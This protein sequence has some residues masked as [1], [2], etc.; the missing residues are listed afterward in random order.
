MRKLANSPQ[1]RQR[2]TFVRC[3]ETFMDV[4]YDHELVLERCIPELLKVNNDPVV[5]VRFALARYVVRMCGPGPSPSP[6]CQ[7]LSLCRLK[8]TDPSSRSDGYCPKMEGAPE[9]L[10]TIIDTLRNDESFDVRQRVAELFP[11]VEAERRP[12]AATSAA[13][14]S[15]PSPR[16]LVRRTSSASSAG[17]AGSIPLTVPLRSPGTPT[18]DGVIEA[19][20]SILQLENVPSPLQSPKVI[21]GYELHGYAFEESTSKEEALKALGETQGLG[22]ADDSFPEGGHLTP[23]PHAPHND[24]PAVDYFGQASAS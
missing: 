11:D 6:S 20:E 19:P 21:P 7:D 16:P 14:S 22:L 23:T 9:G 2:R 24:R 8:L 10:V 17:S 15:M 13:P 12:S 18:L 1:Y 4:E 5:D 3:M